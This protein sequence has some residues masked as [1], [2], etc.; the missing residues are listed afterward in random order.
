MK[1]AI[2]CS[3]T[4]QLKRKVNNEQEKQNEAWKHLLLCKLRLQ[5]WIILFYNHSYNG[6]KN[7]WVEEA[8]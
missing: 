7:S 5:I 6:K 1:N 4:C 3:T 8:I 2:N